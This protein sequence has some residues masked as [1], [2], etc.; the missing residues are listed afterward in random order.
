[1]KNL[2]NYSYIFW[3]DIL[4]S[5]F[6]YTEERANLSTSLISRCFAVPI[7]FLSSGFARKR[8]TAEPI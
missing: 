5:G 4:F 7:C 3:N 6:F 1:M 2:G 8:T